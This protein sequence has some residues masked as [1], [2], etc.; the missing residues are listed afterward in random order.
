MRIPR[1]PGRRRSTAVAALAVTAGLTLAAAPPATAGPTTGGRAATEAA[2]LARAA[3]QDPVGY[4]RLAHLSPDTPAVDVYLS[5]PDAAEPRVFPAVGYGAVSTYLP[6]PAGRYAVAM[7]T[8][9][10]PADEQPVLTTEVAVTAGE[11]YTV[12]GVGRYADLGLRV[13]TDDLTAP[14]RGQAKVRV[15]QASVRAPVLDVTAVDGPPIAEQVQFATTTGYRP[16]EPGPWRLRLGGT[17]G[18][19]TDARVTLTGGAVYSLLV[20]DDERGG[21]TAEL[22]EDARGST[23]TPTGGVDTGAGGLALRGG[24]ALPGGDDDA[25]PTSAEAAGSAGTEAG[26]A[27]GAAG[28][29]YPMIVGAGLAAAVAGGLVLLRRRWRPVP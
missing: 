28:R 9:G 7:R 21:L 15:V 23:V 26:D 1:T 12:A 13:L 24:V 10:A 6:V 22:R 17:N 8:A 4:V 27:G 20:L 18:P 11:A 29:T 5:A 19:R 3:G 14:P 25:Q 16:V 2:A